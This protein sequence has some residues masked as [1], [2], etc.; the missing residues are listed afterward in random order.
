MRPVL[1]LRALGLGDA[2]T[3]VPALRSI[4]TIWPGHRVVLAGPAEIGRL[5][6]QHGVVDEALPLSGLDAGGLQR[7]AADR[8]SLEAAVNLHGCGPESHRLLQSLQPRTLLAHRC[9]AAGHPCGPEWQ[10][11][12]HEVDR[13]LRLTDSAG[14]S[15][16]AEDL[17]LRSDTVPADHVVLHPGAA[18]GSRR[19]PVERWI[20]VARE[21]AATGHEVIVTGG[22]GESA[23]CD[24]IGA[25]APVIVRAHGSL[26][27]LARTV[28]SATLLI[29]G[30]T[31]VAHLATAFGTPSVTLF[32][33]VSPVLWGPRIDRGIHVVLW[34]GDDSDPRPGSAEG[35]ELDPRLAC[36]QAPEVV[37]A[38]LPL[39]ALTAHD[40]RPAHD[41]PTLHD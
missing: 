10:P 32:G 6:V 33:P 25:Q 2:L 3:A 1:V 14:G 35:E 19:W 24:V 4:R 39:L 31:G 7:W 23:L 27:D 22:P 28:A 38:A 16:S 17:R 9:P 30:D 21:L 13:W 37:D 11:H 34:H 15:G 5:L 18:H 29:S 20:T 26:E 12:L 40:R 36:I 41:R 8:D